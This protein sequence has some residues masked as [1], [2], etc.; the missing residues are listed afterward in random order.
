MLEALREALRSIMLDDTPRSPDSRR[1]SRG[2]GVW[3][4]GGL[5][6]AEVPT[7]AGVADSPAGEDHFSGVRA[8]FVVVV[9]LRKGARVVLGAHQ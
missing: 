8:V 2:F 5:G 3:D 6:G 4:R 7:A 1:V 9:P